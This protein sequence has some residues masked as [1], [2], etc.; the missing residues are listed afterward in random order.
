MFYPKVIH[1]QCLVLEV[2]INR[3]SISI[4]IM[5]ILKRRVETASKNDIFFKMS[6]KESNS[7]YEDTNININV[8]M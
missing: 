2:A 1:S 6:L 4:S 5:R 3:C 8:Y 7:Q